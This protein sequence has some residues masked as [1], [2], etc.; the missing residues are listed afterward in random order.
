MMLVAAAVLLC[1]SKHSRAA[2]CA[3]DMNTDDEDIF[4]LS[5]IQKNDNVCRCAMSR[6][7]DDDSIDLSSLDDLIQV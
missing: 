2:C 7:V 6:D 5:H 1:K 4:N 3:A